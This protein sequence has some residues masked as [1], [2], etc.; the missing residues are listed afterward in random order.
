MLVSWHYL[1]TCVADVLP[2]IAQ[3]RVVLDSGAFSAA[4]SGKP[5]SLL[6]YAG[7]LRGNAH[8]FDWCASLDV[9]GDPARSFANWQALR[10][11]HPGVVPA[12]HCGT[13]L[14]WLQRYMDA[15]VPRVAFGG[16]VPYAK[17]L[18]HTASPA[19]QWLDAAFGMVQG[20]QLAVHGFGVT[21][22]SIVFAYPWT[23]VDSS[24]ALAKT[25]YREVL[26]ADGRALSADE[27]V[28]CPHEVRR[29]A[30]PWEVRGGSP[31]RSAR[32]KA[33]LVGVERALE[34]STLE[35]LYHAVPPTAGGSTRGG[36][37]EG[38]VRHLLHHPS[39]HKLPALAPN[40]GRRVL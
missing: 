21:G 11:S 35:T 5:I 38:V 1:R 17:T 33:N 3:L 34:G 27:G 4:N 9:I 37:F 20:T 14:Q 10:A 8:L 19:R 25:R 24:V 40:R 13:D 29:I 28:S 2:S 36:D 30:D 26:Q 7:F 31:T 6:E 15:G 16:L 22:R 23:T 39:G 32:L 12:V 18:R